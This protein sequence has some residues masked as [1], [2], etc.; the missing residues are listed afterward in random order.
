MAGLL[1]WCG[2]RGKS[3]AGEGEGD[4]WYCTALLEATVAAVISCGSSRWFLETMLLM[5]IFAG[6]TGTLSLSAGCQ[7]GSL[8]LFG[9][10]FEGESGTGAAEGEGESAMGAMEVTCAAEGRRP[11]ALFVLRDSNASGGIRVLLL[12]R[13]EDSCNCCWRGYGSGLIAE[14]VSQQRRGRKGAFQIN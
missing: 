5:L 10:T 7:G 2:M 12:L 13:D 1:G 3:N 9:G 11:N 14:I 6:G 4:C 8:L